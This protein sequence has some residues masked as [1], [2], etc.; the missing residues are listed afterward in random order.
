MACLGDR[1][2]EAEAER[3]RIPL[4]LLSVGVRGEGS[5]G[6]AAPRSVGVEFAAV[7]TGTFSAVAVVWSVGVALGAV[8]SS[9][10]VVWP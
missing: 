3:I 7:R 8:L 4:G 10:V 6:S 1:S 5:E 2:A 9:V